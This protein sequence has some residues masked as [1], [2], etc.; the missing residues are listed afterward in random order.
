MVRRDA[1]LK[2]DLEM[3][4]AGNLTNIYSINALQM[5]Q[6]EKLAENDLHWDD[7]ADLIL[8]CRKEGKRPMFS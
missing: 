3:L 5:A 6:N 8:R 7:V 2:A 1:I 4:V